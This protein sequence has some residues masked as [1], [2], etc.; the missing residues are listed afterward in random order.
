[1]NKLH[2]FVTAMSYCTKLSLKPCYWVL[3]SGSVVFPF[4]SN[5]QFPPFSQVTPFP[6]VLLHIREMNRPDYNPLFNSQVCSKRS[7][8]YVSNIWL[9]SF[10][11]QE[12]FEV[13]LILLLD[14]V[15][16]PSYSK[17][18]DNVF[19]MLKIYNKILTCV[20]QNFKQKW[21]SP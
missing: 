12:I 18:N 4:N 7:Q 20:T 5:S 17:W 19:V 1:M 13:L 2:S 3:N 6:W 15:D 16:I 9:H 21:T 14:V 11:D 10:T 8:S